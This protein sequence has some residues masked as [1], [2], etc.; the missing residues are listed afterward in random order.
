MSSETWG[1]NPWSLTSEV[2][3]IGAVKLACWAS[4]DPPDDG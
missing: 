2:T 4:R 3:R 1:E